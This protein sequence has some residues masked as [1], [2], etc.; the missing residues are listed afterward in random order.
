MKNFPR[1]FTP[2]FGVWAR[3]AALLLSF[4]TAVSTSGAATLGNPSPSIG[5]KPIDTTSRLDQLSLRPLSQALHLGATSSATA[6]PN[7]KTRAMA[8]KLRKRISTLQT[9]SQAAKPVTLSRE[10]SEGLARLREKVGESLTIK[11]RR[12]ARTPR[13]IGGA[14]L[15]RSVAM[16]GPIKDRAEQTARTFLRS[17][18]ALLRLDDPDTEMNLHKNKL[19]ELGRTHLRFQQHYRGL[20]VWPA[21]L[22][23][24]L[25]PE[26]DVDL[27]NGAYVETPRGL[28]ITASIVAR[29]AIER[30][31]L[32]LPN[33]ANAAI[34]QPELIIYAPGRRTLSAR[35]GRAGSHIC[36]LQ[37]A[38]GRRCPERSHPDGIRHGH[39]G[40]RGRIR[41]RSLEPNASAQRLARE[42]HLLHGRHLQTDVPDQF[43]STE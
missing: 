16:H 5:A 3:L 21:E 14:K 4:A 6:T 11:G 39:D 35:V 22:I 2:Q 38:S 25:D 17:N 12:E 41:P 10:Q 24:H 13:M 15:E 8:R 42:R 33:S 19:D 26:G 20:R 28:D 30:A 9:R 29:D 40:E 43:E 18:R 32:R 34:S 1:Q 7:K 27:M 23:V 31:R 37:L 36:Q